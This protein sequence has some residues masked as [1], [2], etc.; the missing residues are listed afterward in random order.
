MTDIRLPSE[1]R[2][3]LDAAKVKNID[4]YAGRRVRNGAGKVRYRSSNGT[5]AN[6]ATSEAAATEK[7]RSEARRSID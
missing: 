3:L 6:H 5:A 1:I 4:M 7:R 2:K